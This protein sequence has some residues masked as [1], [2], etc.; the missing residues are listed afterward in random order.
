MGK[1]KKAPK[2]LTPEELNQIVGAKLAKKGSLLK[3]L[4]KKHNKLNKLDKD[5]ADLTGGG[6]GPK[7]AHW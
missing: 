4:Y 1:K 2:E 3:D 6:I 7:A 5:I